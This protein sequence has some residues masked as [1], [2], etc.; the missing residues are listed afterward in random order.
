MRMSLLSSLLI[1]C[2]IS[3]FCLKGENLI[4]NAGFE[5]GNAGFQCI[6][7]LRP[8]T[9]PSLQYEGAVQD[10]ETAVS[11]RSSLCLP[12]RFAEQTA[13]VLPE[14]VLTPDAEY[15]FSFWAKSS[16]EAMPVEF[17]ITSASED[18]GWDSRQR[19]FSI[20]RTWRRFTFTFRTAKARP[21]ER[22][23]YYGLR[24][25][26]CKEP[27][28]PSGN[29]WLDNLQLNRGGVQAWT[30]AAPVEC[31]ALPDRSVYYRNEGNIS[32]RFLA[33]NYSECQKNI[34]ARLLL[35]EERRG[36]F[37]AGSGEPRKLQEVELTLAPGES[38]L[39][40]IHLPILQYGAYELSAEC[41][42][43][44]IR[45]NFVVIGKYVSRPQ[46]SFPVAVNFGAGGFVI[47][48][49][50]GEVKKIG[51]RT[52][53]LNPDGLAA[54]FAAMGCRLVRDHDTEQCF[55]WRVVEPAEEKFDFSLGERVVETWKRHGIDMMVVLGANDFIN[56]KDR[57]ENHNTISGMPSWL[58]ERSR[59]APTSNYLKRKKEQI[60]LPPM[61]AWQR[62]AGEIAS[63]FRGKIPFY[64]IMNEPNLMMDPVTY[65]TYLAAATEAIRRADPAAK[66]VGI[67]S[68]GDL[69]AD[70]GS[71]FAE[72][73][74]KGALK[75]C[76]IVSFHPYQAPHL[77]SLIRADDQIRDLKRQLA[78]AGHP[79]VP[80][81]NSE[82]YY[83]NGHIGKGF[84][85]GCVHPEDVVKRALT[86]L[87]E[88]IHRSI[89]IHASQLFQSATP[90]L[91]TSTW[92]NN[93]FIPNSLFVA[94]NALARLFDGASPVRKFQYPNGVVCYLFRREDSAIAALWNYSERQGIHV[95]LSGFRVMDLFG[96]PEKSGE[97]ELKAS[98]FLLTLPGRSE[99][100]FAARLEKL[101]FRLARPI[102]TGELAR[103]VG[104]RLF[105]N[106]YNDS[107]RELHGTAGLHGGGLIAERPIRFS[108]PS[109]GRRLLELPIRIGQ[110]EKTE[111]VLYLGGHFF[112]YPLKIV[113]NQFVRKKFEMKNVSGKIDWD[114]RH[115]IL[116]AEIL[117]STNAGPTGKRSPW[118]T[119]C[120]ELF[121][122]LNPLFLPKRH[123]QAYTSETFRLF[124][125]PRDTIKLHSM[126]NVQ[127]GECRLECQENDSGYHFRL[128]I[129]AVAG[130]MLG[131]DFKVDD[132]PQDGG[133]V[134]EST[135]TRG[136]ELY[137]NRCN[138]GLIQKEEE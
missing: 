36:N 87:G 65:L 76:D 95:D 98:P 97:K 127:P 45:S 49:R 59:P 135:L 27:N 37:P 5:L 16:L 4:F 19:V 124:I 116:E 58:L 21:R 18:F 90:H 8:N 72:S 100:V 24:F 20:G 131:F 14:V 102:T 85:S 119:D 44:G 1:L 120:V 42:A 128:T 25:T 80:L 26:F 54:L 64:E 66:I 91:E 109:N 56:K 71:F 10:R 7:Y 57:S 84:R 70:T 46:P 117:D 35:R 96:N 39:Q 114:G 28:D 68:T 81:W 34:A 133:K 6:K 41:S 121:F 52:S 53:S 74:K 110:G 33:V 78:A 30:P 122:D 60:F 134:Q 99:N 40:P 11:G 13:L 73:V 2:L 129:P 67:C 29:L 112:H 104:N 108:V 125:T 50:W 23:R 106:L 86:D 51:F 43:E 31:A 105:L 55:Q 111:L 17:A 69:G 107:D 92:R 138:F 38:I 61:E 113:E 93:T 62:F 22:A 82:L 12:N 132:A 123:A 63:R 118:E 15:T 88:G 126:G 137:K 94:Y 101:S 48:P 32:G 3:A 115:I 89:L 79:G 103:R 136:V 9:N 77:A 75:Y 130:E 83:L 47:P